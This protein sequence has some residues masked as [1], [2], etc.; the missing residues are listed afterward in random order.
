M[1]FRR[2]KDKEKKGNIEVIKCWHSG[3]P[4]RQH[5]SCNLH[6][7]STSLHVHRKTLELQGDQGRVVT[8]KVSLEN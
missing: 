6:E 1:S 4:L 5:T 2:E 7:R 3:T 8:V